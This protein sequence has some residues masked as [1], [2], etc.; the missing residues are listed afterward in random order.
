MRRPSTL[1]TLALSTLLLATTT[2]TDDPIDEARDAPLLV[3]AAT[4]LTDAFT[5]LEAAYEATHPGVDIRI[6]TAASSAL[7]EQILAGAPADV[8]AS[9]DPGIMTHVV[10]A[11]M[12]VAEPQVFAT[13]RLQIAV[14][15]GNPA[16]IIGLEDFAD[17]T[18]LIG[19]CASQVPCGMLG[20]AVLA[21]AGI[22][23][24]IDTDEPN[25]RALLTKLEE[26][27]LDVGL[28]YV[29]DVLSS[30]RIEGID[31]PP[32]WNVETTYPIAV[33]ADSAAPSQAASF[34]EFMLSPE[35]VAILT[36]RGFGAP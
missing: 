21:N 16:G 23:P 36:A 33:L 14:P 1:A 3:F 11:G 5:D 28:T 20:R 6:S 2:C 26:D 32:E 24:S 31:V 27:E 4:S 13:S 10:E 34:I 22:I 7:R 25:V 8:F 17:P 30:D 18:R 19:L 15:V 9:A 29:T 12:V 35:G